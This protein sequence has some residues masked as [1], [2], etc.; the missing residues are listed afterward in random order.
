MLHLAQKGFIRSYQIIYIEFTLWAMALLYAGFEMPLLLI[1]LTV[2]PILLYVREIVHGST[3]WAIQAKA[4]DSYVLKSNFRGVTGEEIGDIES[5]FRTVDTDHYVLDL[6]HLSSKLP[7]HSDYFDKLTGHILNHIKNK[8]V[9]IDM[10]YI[11]NGDPEKDDIYPELANF[12]V[13]FVKQNKITDRSDT[14]GAV[15]NLS[16][17]I[18]SHD[19]VGYRQRLYYL[20]QP[21]LADVLISQHNLMT[22]QSMQSSEI[23]NDNPLHK[24]L[25]YVRSD[26]IVKLISLE[27]ERIIK[28]ILCDS[29][30]ALFCYYQDVNPLSLLKYDY[31]SFD[32]RRLILQ[33]VT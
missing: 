33:K 16:F 29:D 3:P 15:I 32:L 8:L 27:R 25:S 14:K 7:S 1:P 17:D 31:I 5:F 19:D 6:Y 12:L 11:A 22:A 28:S 24:I 26:E 2:F 9:F 21:E 13:A 10:Q 4:I 30:I 23:L 20:E 18:G